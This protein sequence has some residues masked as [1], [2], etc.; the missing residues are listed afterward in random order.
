MQPIAILK[1]QPTPGDVHVNR[2]LTNVSVAWLQDQARYIAGRVF[3]VVGVAKQSDL[4]FIFSR[5]DWLRAVA[6][7][8]APSTES[9]GGGYAMTT[10]SYAADVW[11][12]H[13][14]VSDQI[15]SNADNPLSPD[16]SAVQFATQAC[17]TRREVNWAAKYF[18]TG[19]WT[20][21]TTGT[22]IV[23]GTKWD[24]ASGSPIN[25][26]RAQ[27]YSVLSKTGF[28]PNKL[29][30]GPQTWRG[31]QDAPDFVDRVKAGQTPG[32]PAL[33]NLAA[34]ATVLEIEEVLVSEA[35]VNTGPEGGTEATS[36]IMGDDDAVLL[37]V[38]PAPTIEAPSAGYTFAW[39]GLFGAGA[40]GNRIRRFRMESLSS[41][42][43]ECEM[44]WDQK[45][46]APELGA[47]FDDTMT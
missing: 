37:Y 40:A 36:F 6:E 19:V 5:A 8:R 12:F 30:L 26:I 2:P 42:R 13:K 9:A 24:N 35:V 32:G 14:D 44:A 29:V 15:R 27:I 25:D 47:F 16:R 21:S 38:A 31:L 4:Y 39:T 3:P 10:G 22:D 18:T 23:P 46:V 20:G 33:V 11:A 1:A 41:D 45:V 7:K 43:V 34:L 17:M 28:K